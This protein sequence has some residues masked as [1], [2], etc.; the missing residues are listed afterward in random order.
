MVSFFE[1]DRN[2]YIVLLSVILIANFPFGFRYFA[3]SDDYNAYGVFSL[4]RENIWTDVMLRFNIYGMRP[5]AGLT[6]AYIIAWFWRGGMAFVLLA[7]TAMRFG[8]IYLLDKI[9]TKSGIVWG[10]AAA[11]FFAVFPALTEA[12]YWVSASS[13]CLRFFCVWRRCMGC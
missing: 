8:S 5:L 7:I 9:F 1:N 10:R 4:F 12:A 11:V 2:F 3:F 13:L 6:D